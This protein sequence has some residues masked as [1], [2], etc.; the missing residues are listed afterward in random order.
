M[1]GLSVGEGRR[2][3]R[4]NCRILRPYILWRRRKE[5]DTE[6]FLLIK[7]K[8]EEEQRRK[9]DE[10]RRCKEREK[11]LS[12]I[13]DIEQELTEIREKRSEL[14]ENVKILQERKHQLFLCLKNSLLAKEYVRKE[15]TSTIFS[16]SHSNEDNRADSGTGS[17]S[18]QFPQYPAVG[19]PASGTQQE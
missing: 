13:K 4:D 14:E 5:Q 3:A 12:R 2:S 11:R 1:P 8:R 6:T 7:I 18:M 17:L 16:M 19:K 9:E 10:D 15:K